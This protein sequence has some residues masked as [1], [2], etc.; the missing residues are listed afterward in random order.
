MDGTAVTS[1]LGRSHINDHSHVNNAVTVT[2]FDITP[3]TSLW[4]LP[5]QRWYC[6][7]VN[8]IYHFHP[9][10][11]L[12]L[13][14]T[15]LLWTKI[16]FQSFEIFFNKIAIIF[17]LTFH[18][19]IFLYNGKRKPLLQCC[20]HVITQELHYNIHNVNLIFINLFIFNC[21]LYNH[22]KL[23]LD[24]LQYKMQLLKEVCPHKNIYSIHQLTIYITQIITDKIKT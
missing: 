7:H 1:M 20:F 5:C 4:P 23:Q 9:Y 14:F 12:N 11:L 15:T 16:I 13:N 2:I 21:I 19:N 22:I 17:L 6:C 18:H 24:L 3:V 8:D 10:Q